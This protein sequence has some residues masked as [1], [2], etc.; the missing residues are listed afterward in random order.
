M[1]ENENKSLHCANQDVEKSFY[2]LHAADSYVNL[3]SVFPVDK[4]DKCQ[5]AISV[6]TSEYNII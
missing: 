2:Q 4:V 6:D 5:N 1:S 3:R